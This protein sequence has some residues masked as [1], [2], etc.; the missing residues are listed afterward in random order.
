MYS[1]AIW[2][3]LIILWLLTNTIIAGYM[4]RIFR[5]PAYPPSFDNVKSLIADGIIAEILILVWAVPALIWMFAFS[6]PFVQIALLV[7]LALMFPVSLFLYANTG[8]FAECLRI[9]KIL[10]VIQHTGWWR[11]LGTWCIAILCFLFAIVIT[12]IFWFLITLF[13]SVPAILTSVIKYGIFGYVMLMF[14]IFF[15]GFFASV[16]RDA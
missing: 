16:F 4:I 14:N 3:G 6:Y 1:C 5:D 15:A 10:T 8:N 9:S 12:G 2:G 11:Y 13:P 7:F